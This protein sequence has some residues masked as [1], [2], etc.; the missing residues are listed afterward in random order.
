MNNKKE[1]FQDF[2]HDSIDFIMIFII[3]IIVGSIINWR[4]NLLFQKSEA[5]IE[6]S[7]KIEESSDKS[8]IKDNNLESSNSIFKEN[9]TQEKYIENKSPI[10]ITIP[11]G[12]DTKSIGDILSN[13]GLISDSNDFISKCESMGISTKLKSGKYEINPNESLENII[14]T[15]IK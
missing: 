15:L 9:K 13:H 10:T 3:I 4:L 11:T 12:S 7:S 14:E 1:T 8:S 5:T 6:T 2:I